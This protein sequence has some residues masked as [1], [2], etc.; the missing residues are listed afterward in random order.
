MTG[1]IGTVKVKVTTT[2]YEDFQLTLVLNAVNQIKPTPDG[3]ITAAE[4]TYGDALSKSTILGKM[5]RIPTPAQRSTV[6]SRQQVSGDS[7]HSERE[8]AWS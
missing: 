1:Q 8:H 3:E 7:D 2:N 4:I 6:P 5:K